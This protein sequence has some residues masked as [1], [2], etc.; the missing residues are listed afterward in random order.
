MKNVAFLFK[1]PP[2]GTSL[3]CEGLDMAL[4]MSAIDIPIGLFFICDG[5]LQL[6]PNQKPRV[7]LSRDYTPAF[8]MLSVYDGQSF[9][10]D[11]DSMVKRGLSELD[12]TMSVSVL[13][14]EEWHHKIST[15][16]S[17]V[18]F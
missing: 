11:Y 15:Y 14:R 1:S 8:D 18:A 7:I 13:K 6:V 10:L 16:D 17:I 3:G 9:Y 2:H 5:V 4:S 12:Y